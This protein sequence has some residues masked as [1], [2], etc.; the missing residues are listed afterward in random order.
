M[1]EHE[2]NKELSEINPSLRTGTV[3]TQACPKCGSTRIICDPEYAE[4]VCMNCGVTVKQ[5]D[6]TK[7]SEQKN[8][9]VK[10]RRSKHV[11][12]DEV[13]TYTIHNRGLSTTIEW[14]N[15]NRYSKNLAVQKTRT[16]RLCGWQRRVRIPNSTEHNL[17]STLSEITKVANK[18]SLPKN[19][20][21][22]AVSIY[23]KAA[24]KNLTKGRSIQSVASATLYLACRQCELPITLDE[25]AQT[26]AV[27]KREVGKS[28]RYLIKELNYSIPPLQPVQY[29]TKFSSQFITQEKTEEIMHKILSAVKNNKLISGCRPAGI[30]AAASY[31]ASI[32]AGENITQKKVADIAQ[33]TETNVRKNYRELEKELTVEVSI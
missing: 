2:D 1:M 15:Q 25:I 30:V 20:L 29:V 5:K 31:A 26:L 12:N 28:Y 18:L 4:I 9:A 24:K 32:L 6:A 19:V 13:L 17:T 33:V 23:Q 22:T 3:E 10:Q 16:Y 21:E 14:D 7:K 8:N 27:N 11:K